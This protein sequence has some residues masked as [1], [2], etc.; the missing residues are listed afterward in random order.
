VRLSIG[1]A[2]AAKVKEEADRYTAI[3]AYGANF[4]RMGVK[5]ETTAITAETTA[6]VRAAIAKWHGVVDEVIFRAIV[7][8]DTVDENLALV[9]AAKPA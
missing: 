7:A 6:D 3:P 4:Q 1:R 5:A 8:N 9:R 2:A